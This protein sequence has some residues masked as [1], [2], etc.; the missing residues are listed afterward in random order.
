MAQ[1]RNPMSDEALE[2]FIQGE[3]E[4]NNVPGLSVTVVKG[5]QV[6]WEW[7]FGFADLAAST[8]AAQRLPCNCG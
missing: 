8:P 3:I 6:A 1:T 2:A 7:G 5:D 4:A